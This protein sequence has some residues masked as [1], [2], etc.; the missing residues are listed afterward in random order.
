VSLTLFLAKLFKQPLSILL[1]VVDMDNL[2]I[3]LPKILKEEKPKL[4]KRIEE[5]VVFEEKRKKLLKFIDEL[6]KGAKNLSD[7]DLVKLGRK[8]KDGRFKNLKKQGLF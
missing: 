5:L 3:K 1:L 7:D 2:E 8:I 4:E 6:M